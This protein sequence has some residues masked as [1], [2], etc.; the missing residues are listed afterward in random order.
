VTLAKHPLYAWDS[1]SWEE[2]KHPRGE[3]GKFSSGG[4]GSSIIGKN[5]SVSRG[6]YGTSI[7]TGSN[8]PEDFIAAHTDRIDRAYEMGE[9]IKMIVE[10]LKFRYEHRPHLEKTPAQMAVRRVRV[11]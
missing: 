6:V 11:P 10:E 2:S 9:P 4:S 8:L 5:Q 3:G 1:P 7:R